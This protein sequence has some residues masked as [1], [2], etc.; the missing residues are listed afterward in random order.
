MANGGSEGGPYY[1]QNFT[2]QP[3]GFGYGVVGGDMAVFGGGPP[4]YD[5]L[6]WRS[7]SGHDAAWLSM[8]PSRML[9]ARHRVVPFTGRGTEL[10]SLERWRDHEGARLS[11]LWLQAPG[12][13]GK[14]RLSMEFATRTAAL[15]WQ[16]ATAV[17]GPGV[18]TPSPGSVDLSGKE[19]GVLLFVDYADRWPLPTLVFLL[20]NSLL[21]R[22]GVRAR[23]LLTARSGAA[24]P[25]LRKELDNL[26]ADLVEQKLGPLDAPGDRAAM[27]QAAYRAFAKVSG[28]DPPGP[29]PDAAAFTGPDSGHTLSLHT[30][31]LAAVDAHQHGVRPP[32]DPAA[33][34]SYLLDRERAQWIHHFTDGRHR[35]PDDTGLLSD[36]DFHTHPD[37]LHRA[38][39]T[40]TLAGA[41]PRPDATRLLEHVLPGRPAARV[42]ADHMVCYPPSRP[43]TG[44]QALEPLKPDRLAEDFIALTLPDTTADN[45]A[46]PWAG[47]VLDVLCTA[48]GPWA[49]YSA[50]AV[51]V[52]VAAAQRWPHVGRDHLRRVLLR[53]PELAV[54]AG[55]AAL[56]ALTDLPGIDSAVLDAVERAFPTGGDTAIASGMAAVTQR[57]IRER[58]A[59]TRDPASRAALLLLSARRQV[60]AGR[61][62]EAIRDAQRGLEAA[63]AAGW[64]ALPLAG[65]ALDDLALSLA[66]G[67]GRRQEALRCAET[68][69]DLY[70]CL[71][72]LEP[73]HRVEYA[74]ALVSL[75][76]HRDLG[77]G[78]TEDALTA[79]SEAVR[80][81]R[82]CGPS[83]Q[84]QLAFALRVQGRLLGPCG[85]PEEGLAAVESATSLLRERVVSQPASVLPALAE[86]LYE[87]AALLGAL[88][89]AREAVEVGEEC[90]SL[91]RD[92]A[93]QNPKTFT[94]SLAKALSDLG[95]HLAL[96]GRAE[97]GL[98]SSSEA[99]TVARQAHALLGAAGEPYLASALSNLASRLSMAMRHAEALSAAGEATAMCRRLVARNRP[100]FLE[101]FALSLNNLRNAAIR[102][103]SFEL[104]RQTAQEVAVVYGEL[105]ADN[106]RFQGRLR[107][108]NEL[109]ELLASDAG[110]AMAAF[111]LAG[112]DATGMP[113]STAVS[114]DHGQEGRAASGHP[115]STALLLLP[116]LL[117]L[118]GAVAGYAADSWIG[119]LVTGYCCFLA[120]DRFTTAIV[121]TELDLPAVYRHVPELGTAMGFGGVVG[122]AVGAG[123]GVVAGHQGAWLFGGLAA[124]TLVA[125]L[126]LAGRADLGIAR[127][128]AATG[129][130]LFAAACVGVGHA[131]WPGAAGV[132]VGIVVATTVTALFW[133]LAGKVAMAGGN[134]A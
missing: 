54:R 84:A 127:V 51:T 99:V 83:H 86:C 78:R 104:A 42:L 90:V 23:V 114:P 126:P 91:F 108:A 87:R 26:G 132:T 102:A 44:G 18:L 69:T 117:V 4:V 67:A 29:V 70:R 68:A 32:A 50:H 79:A 73:A 77:A 88:K 130:V 43:L 92:L 10:R 131:R 72:Q 81:L 22:P 27:F 41:M 118:A 123:I 33:S 100:A 62:D 89:R 61:Y 12:G 9:N 98:R 64:S 106:D 25:L 53:R 63:H 46:H 71:A 37:I 48:D 3:G 13:Q 93:R 103:Q 47:E 82:S 52:L 1:Q 7:P 66:I 8:L 28:I 85:R 120:A 116:L 14:T 55:S 15:G 35:I 19:P 134:T 119:A 111:A 40:A 122:I 36:A 45:P 74:R 6:D 65:E 112:G 94:G 109:S 5:L 97:D 49:P 133:H 75:A 101:Q 96:A 38:V 21:N 34:T 59:R 31:A 129:K 2:V 125:G 16:V 30:A 58:L 57:V 121:R 24:L 76:V 60:V 39:F 115:P 11:V 113:L 56:A 128:L 80:I 124:G 17:H 95:Y 105:A 107:A 20:G 110:R